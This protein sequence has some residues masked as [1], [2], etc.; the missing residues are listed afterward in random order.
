M[1]FIVPN[2]VGD[3]IR[4]RSLDHHTHSLW[5]SHVLLLKVRD[6]A[7]CEDF[8][9]GCKVRCLGRLAFGMDR[10]AANGGSELEVRVLQN[11]SAEGDHLSLQR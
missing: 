6:A 2:V 3:R 8:P 11:M 9:M 7:R 1:T 5:E 10:A 4:L